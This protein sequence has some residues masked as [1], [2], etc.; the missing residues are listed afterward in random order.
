[1]RITGKCLWSSRLR[2]TNLLLDNNTVVKKTLTLY[3]LF[4]W[5]YKHFSYKCSNESFSLIYLL[6]IQNRLL[7]WFLWRKWW[8]C[9]LL[10][11]VY[12]NINISKVFLQICTRFNKQ[13]LLLIMFKRHSLV[14]FFYLLVLSDG[15]GL[16]Q[17]DCRH[18]M[19]SSVVSTA[20]ETQF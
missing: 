19:K 2:I 8:W 11:V 13:Y 6:W 5:W 15:D 3:L 14:D 10:L 18:T 20:L 7:G 12:A 16:I 1:M 17:T 4:A 9:L